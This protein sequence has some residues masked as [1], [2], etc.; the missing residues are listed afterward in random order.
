MRRQALRYA[1]YEA[2]EERGPDKRM[3]RMVPW[4]ASA[5]V[6]VGLGL[7][8]AFVIYW[9]YHAFAA[10]NDQ[11]IVIPSSFEDPPL[12]DHP[13]GSPHPGMKGD[14]TRDAA[15]ER[16]RQVMKSDGWSSHS[17]V[18]DAAAM[19]QGAGEEINPQGIFAGAGGATGP[20]VNGNGLDSADVAAFGKGGGAG[21]GP[22]STF[23]GT[24]GSASRI[25]YMVD[26]SGSMLSS[27]SYV[28][29]ELARSVRNLVPLQYFNVVTV[30]TVAGPSDMTVDRPSEAIGPADA[31]VRATPENKES[32]LKKMATI[33]PEGYND[34]IVPPFLQ[35]FQVAFA[36]KPQ[37]I[38]FLTDGN[39]DRALINRVTKLNP[40]KVVVINALSYEELGPSDFAPQR[41]DAI[42]HDTRLLDR[43]QIL[44]ELA[45]RN[46]GKGQLVFEG[47][48]KS[49]TVAISAGQ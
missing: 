31:L 37:L 1:R 29:R 35:A 21:N 17:K 7:V 10:G 33:A 36:M 9:T 8:A 5:V 18:A 34:G 4:M 45:A 44:D 25:V 30:G 11:L 41:F 28:N 23:Y 2:R 22:R 13:G 32:L 42:V 6:H 47:P 39:S 27:F 3:L 20:G 19:L 40:N 24:G 49:V 14:P 12:S 38:Y 16:L 15:Q 46:G 43:V 26:I 48:G